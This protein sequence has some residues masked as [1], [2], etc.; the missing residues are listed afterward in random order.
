MKPQEIADLCADIGFATGVL[1]GSAWQ[2]T[3]P[4]QKEAHEK[5]INGLE[6]VSLA[7]RGLICAAPQ[8]TET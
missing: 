5:A 1:T 7:L 2:A 6:R 8:G 4:H 3:E